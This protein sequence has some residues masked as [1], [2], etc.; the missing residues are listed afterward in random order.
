MYT[1]GQYL[2]DR[3]EEI[4]IDKVFGVP[5]DYNL[6]FLD[7]IQNHEG[8]SWQGNTN[9]LNAAYAADGYARER[10]V[11][12]LVTTFGVGELSAINGTAGSFAEQVPVIHIVGSPTMNVQSNKKLVHHSLG[13]GNF[14]NFS[15][16]AKE[17]TA[18]TTMLTEENAAS[19]IDR[20]LETALLE[21][22]PVYI[23]LP[24]DIAHKAIVKPAK[25]L[26][27]EKS[28]GEREAQLAEIILSHLEKA[29]Q[30]IVIVG[31]EIARFQIRERFENWIN[32]TKLPVTNLA[33][34]KGSFNEEN[35]HF[36]GTYYPAFSDKSV[37]DYVDNSDFVLH[38]GGKIIDN[39]TSS[40]SQGF[41]TE[42][43]LTAANDIIMLPDGSTYSGISLNGLLAELEKLNFTFADTAA[44]QAE[45]AVFEPQAETPLKQDRFHQAVM[46]FLKADDV[47][48]TE[49]GTSSFGLML[50]PLK[51]GMNLISQTLWGSI[52]YTLPAMI[53]SQIAAPERR[54]ILSIGDG[55]FQLTAQE[56]STIFREKL[57][58]VIF[59]I[60]NDG[61]TV[62]RAIHGEDE[63]YNDIPTWNLQ[64]VAETFGGDAETVDTHNVFT[65][66]DFANTL[67]AI[68][69]TPQKAHV[70]EVHMEQM[71]MPESLR[72]IGLALS[73]QN[74]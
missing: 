58:P 3:L 26:Q 31:H 24:I 62:E 25:A 35:E 73:K 50:A 20:V 36:I 22:R 52:G 64:L 69:A 14:H 53:G 68:D 51:K 39:S 10:G 8:L 17:V 47:L 27:T 59:I 28:S 57:T 23:N 60:N 11:S 61:Y 48:V 29:A 16:M 40:F 6:T 2:V 74:S 71:D 19:E 18:A 1:V 13:M 66:T 32:Q 34:G 12:A 30:P 4:G 54:H 55:S 49:Q 37:L 44:K 43:T 65:E 67:A 38:F 72:Q 21:K 41:K 45:L 7:Y 70:V 56:M 42:N 9:E 5:G 15:E 63:S 46:N 33:Y